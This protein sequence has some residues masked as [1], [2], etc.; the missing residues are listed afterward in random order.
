M[1]EDSLHS[2][3]EDGM[4]YT[5]SYFCSVFQTLFPVIPDGAIRMRCNGDINYWLRLGAW[6]KL[7]PSSYVSL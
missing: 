7:R 6:P 2:E 4:F 1:V 5:L 3:T